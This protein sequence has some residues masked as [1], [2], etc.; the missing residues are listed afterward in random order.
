MSSTLVLLIVSAMTNTIA[1][2]VQL[3]TRIPSAS[4]IP[5]TP[6]K[7]GLTKVIAIRLSYYI[8]ACSATILPTIKFS[9]EMITG[10]IAPG[11]TAVVGTDGLLVVFLFVVLWASLGFVTFACFYSCWVVR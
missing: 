7:A 1:L 6:P 4:A 11:L 5:T 8:P 3:R 10:T 9:M 2:D